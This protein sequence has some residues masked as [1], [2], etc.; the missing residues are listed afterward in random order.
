MNIGGPELL[1]ILLL[2]LSLALFIVWVWSIY[3]IAVSDDRE[4]AAGTKVVWILVVVLVGIIGTAIWYL[5]D[6]RQRTQPTIAS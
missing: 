1:I 4:F 2:L 3:R 5:A 6:Y